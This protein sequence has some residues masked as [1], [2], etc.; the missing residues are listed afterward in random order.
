M[1]KLGMR[2]VIGAALIMSS[3]VG[4]HDNSD[5]NIGL[6]LGFEGRYT[7][8]I[9]PCP[10][11]RTRYCG[12]IVDVANETVSPADE[13]NYS[14]MQRGKPLAGKRVL[15]FAIDEVDEAS[16]S[17]YLV[18]SLGRTMPTS[19]EPDNNGNLNVV[20]CGFNGCKPD[21]WTRLE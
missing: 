8:E 5:P 14:P 20:L 3:P 4:A 10:E 18:H 16:G 13:L 19:V 2:A 12:T 7:V 9:E 15:E 11:D 17:V 21:T 1:D 6:F